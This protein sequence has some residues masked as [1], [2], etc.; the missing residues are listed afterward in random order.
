MNLSPRE[1]DKL[2][3]SMAAS[4]YLTYRLRKTSRETGSVVLKADAI[5]YSI[6][7][8][9]Y[10][11]LLVTFALIQLSGWRLWDPI[12]TFPLS[13]Y[14]AYQGFGVGKEAVD[15]LMDRETSPEV[16]ITVKQVVARH[17]EEVIA[18]RPAE[19]DELGS[20]ARN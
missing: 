4:F 1:K 13:A 16:L 19:L 17:A 20:A 15:E 8:Y 7:L 3:I 10:V 14:I 5:H 6:D 2:L 18:V 9:A 12:V 11:V